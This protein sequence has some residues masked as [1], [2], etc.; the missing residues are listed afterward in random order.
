MA[1][2]LVR[3]VDGRDLVMFRVE[4]ARYFGQHAFDILGLHALHHVFLDG[5]KRLRQFRGQ[6]RETFDRLDDEFQRVP[7]EHVG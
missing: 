2:R 1:D 3:S 6:F 5:K 4:K 7:V